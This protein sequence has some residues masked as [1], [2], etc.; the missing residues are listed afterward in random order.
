MRLQG[1]KLLYFFDAGDWESRIALAQA[2]KKNGADVTIGLITAQG[3]AQDKIAANAKNFNIIELQKMLG[4]S[5]SIKASLS[6]MQKIRQIVAQEKPDL[7][8]TVTLKYGFLTALATLDYNKTKKVFTIA[9]LGYLYRSDGVK[10]KILRAV[11]W[12]FLLLAFHGRNTHLIFQNADDRAM[13]INKKITTVQNTSLI[14]GS[15]VYLDRFDANV[16]EQKNDLPLVLM[17]T[18][19]VHEKGVAVFVDAAHILRAKGVNARFEIAGGLTHDNPRAISQEEMKRMTEDGLVTWLG[20]INNM[21]E[22]LKEAALVVYPSYYGEGIPR[23]LLEAC[24]AGCPIITTDHPGCREAVTHEE[25]GLLVPVKDA[26]ATAW[27]IEKLLEDPQRRNQMG[28]MSR[29]KACREFDIH[30]IA[31]LTLDVY[32]HTISNP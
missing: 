25:N 27:A 8:H 6:M 26:Q 14:K 9:G 31:N 15:G 22:K 21:P 12:P 28:A 11:L 16:A 32:R 4:G 1:K 29:N 19:L 7:I 18:R 5:K 2:A 24:A 17:P 13:L 3:Q 10:A 30:D 20:R 23:V